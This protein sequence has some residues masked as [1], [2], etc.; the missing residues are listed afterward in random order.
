MIRALEFFRRTGRRISDLNEEQR[1]Q[2]SPYRVLYLVLTLPRETLYARINR[3]VDRMFEEGLEEE[4][5][6]LLARGVPADSTAMQALGYKEMLD[7]LNGRCT[8]EEAAERIRLGSRHYAKRQLAER[9][10]VIEIIRLP[11]AKWLHVP[12][13]SLGYAYYFNYGE[14][15]EY[16]DYTYIT[17]EEYL[18]RADGPAMPE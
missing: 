4:V 1:E 13:E 10:D 3:R 17:Y 11:H 9:K 18:K 2:E 12:D 6:Q 15:K 14:V 5:R 16:D 7:C 8:R